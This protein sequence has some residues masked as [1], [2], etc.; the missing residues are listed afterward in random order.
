MADTEP[1]PIF[2]K[3]GPKGLRRKRPAEALSSANAVG[4]EQRSDSDGET[5][6]VVQK[7]RRIDRTNPL[8]QATGAVAKRGRWRE[9]IDTADDSAERVVGETPS[10][11]R[12][13][14]ASKRDG[15][16]RDARADATRSAWDAEE[17][18]E[19]K[20]LIEKALQDADADGDEVYRG[21]SGYRSFQPVRDPAA[22]A[23]SGA[24]FRAGPMRAPAN[25]RVTCRFD[26]QPDICKDYKETGY[27]GYGDSCKFMH[28]RGDYKS[29]WQLDREWDEQQ[30]RLQAG[31]ANEF[32]VHSDSDSEELPFACLICRQEFEKPVVTKCGHY[33]CQKCAL[34]RYAKTPKC[35][36][37]G[38][39]TG[40]V[41]KTATRLLEKLREKQQRRELE[42]DE[43]GASD[44]D[45]SGNEAGDQPISELAIR[46]GR[47]GDSDGDGDDDDDDNDDDDDSD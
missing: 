27:C 6:T 18:A 36:A 17:D 13:A 31:D 47:G 10:V 20:A 7:G 11:M 43:N 34:K 4:D 37:C 1:G 22:S 42:G 39:P 9:G 30:G 38:A 28:D 19:A 8:I 41:F 44:G 3:R 24:K 46:S 23:N 21:Q 12:V 26:Y 45:N 29:G 16:G 2:K 35:H 5:T 40:G 25:I 14:Y 15:G 33:F 32:V